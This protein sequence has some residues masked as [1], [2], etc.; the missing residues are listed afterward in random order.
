MSDMKTTAPVT[1]MVELLLTV[2]ALSQEG[3]KGPTSHAIP[4][5]L[6][7]TLRTARKQEL[8]HLDDDGLYLEDMGT[9]LIAGFQI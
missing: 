9:V 3:Y 2:W 5:R 8:V 4:A 7:S 6:M 1:K